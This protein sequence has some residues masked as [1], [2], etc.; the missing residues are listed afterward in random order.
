MGAEGD[1]LEKHNVVSADWKTTLC[2]LEAGKICFFFFK[3]HTKL[4]MAMYFTYLPMISSIATE[5]GFIIQY[6][7]PVTCCC[8]NLSVAGK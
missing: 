6:D 2:R 3:L 4:S 5:P 8:N 1:F 7:T